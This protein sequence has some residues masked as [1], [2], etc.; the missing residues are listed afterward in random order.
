MISR[1][2]VLTAIV[3]SRATSAQT[4]DQFDAAGLAVS[5]RFSNAT[6][7]RRAPELKKVLSGGLE[8][9]TELFGGPPRDSTGAPLKSLAVTVAS[10]PIGAGDADPGVLRITIGPGPMFGFYDWRMTV[11]HEAFHLWNAESFR[12][13][14]PAEQWF[15]EGVSEFYAMQTAAKL[16]LISDMEAIRIAGIAVG[17][18]TSALGY[19]KL[20]FRSAGATKGQHYFLVYYGGWVAALVLDRDLRG[21]THNHRSM[22]DVVRRLYA[23]FNRDTKQYTND[24][25]GVA[26]LQT[27]N[28]DYSVWFRNHIEGPTPIPVSN[29]LNLGD[30]ARFM[31]ARRAGISDVPAPD[32]LLQASLGILK[33]AKP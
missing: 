19:G 3:I 24:N 14:G 10:G 4:T 20:S 17:Y 23:D 30:L 2:A 12:Y 32:S 13:Q 26:I 27:A 7:A 9:Y 25:V 31:Q 29:V 33:Q 5:V 8:R 28:E 22:D 21:R 6:V 1:L 11:L 18:Y 16:G 15:N